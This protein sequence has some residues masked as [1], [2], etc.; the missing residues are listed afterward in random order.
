MQFKAAGNDFSHALGDAKTANGD[1]TGGGAAVL[2]VGGLAALLGAR[3]VWGLGRGILSIGRNLAGGVIE[4]AAGGELAA[5][6]AGAAGLGMTGVGLAGLGLG[7]GVNW[8]DKTY[9]PGFRHSLGLTENPALN[10]A[11]LWA[12]LTGQPM[13][14]GNLDDAPAALG[15]AVAW[16]ES[17]GRQIDPATGRTMLGPMTR[18]GARAIGMMQ[19]MPDTAA[20]LGVNPYDAQQNWSGGLRYLA[21]MLQ[22]YG[23]NVE[24]ALAAYNWGPGK[25]DAAI[26]RHG[27]FSL[28][29]LPKETQ[30][31]VRDI[32]GHMGG[33]TNVG[34]VTIN[35]T[36][37]NATPEQIQR[38][39]Q[40]GIE[41]ALKDQNRRQ[42]I[43]VQ[44]QGVW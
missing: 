1:L 31:Y 11:R 41:K 23:G 43:N 17:G 8:W 28:D 25:L 19:L 42:L 12:A 33:G 9:G 18:S 37:P 40:D 4:G 7:I 21:M 6:G 15:A 27:G 3:T 30:K 22:R 2:T 10:R 29:Y 5:G 26:K 36:N 13:P 24:E 44:A 38:V 35:I 39:T 20:S 34:G 16:R 32:E 14:G